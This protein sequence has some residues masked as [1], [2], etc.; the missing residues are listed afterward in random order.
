MSVNYKAKMIYDAAVENIT[1]SED[2]WKDICRMAGQLYRYEFQNILLVYEQRPGAT[3]VA[4]YD[5]WKKVD[6]Y[7]RRGS[8]G[9]AGQ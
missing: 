6:R 7:V 3:L 2:V 1:K 8:K 4:D 5:T 9:I